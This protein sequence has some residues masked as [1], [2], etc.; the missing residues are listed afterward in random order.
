MVTLTADVTDGIKT[1]T[2]NLVKEG[3]YKSQS[4]VVRDAIRQL[5]LH[6]RVEHRMTRE[7]LRKRIGAAGKKAGITLSQTIR[8]I[9]DED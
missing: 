7:E 1:L 3:L 9:R 5:A 8:E 4:E 2:E 6:Y